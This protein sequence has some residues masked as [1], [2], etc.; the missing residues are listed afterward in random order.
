MLVIDEEDTIAYEFMTNKKNGVAVSCGEVGCGPEHGRRPW[1]LC[2]VNTF[3]YVV[4]AVFLGSNSRAKN[5]AKFRKSCI[6]LETSLTEKKHR[7]V[8]F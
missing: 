1:F 8:V 2:I 3:T 6:K 7:H 4:Q 5:Y